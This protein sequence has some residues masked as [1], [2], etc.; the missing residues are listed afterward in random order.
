MQ[1]QEIIKWIK[2]SRETG[3]TDK[4]IREQLRASGWTK[5]HIDNVMPIANGP[6]SAK[7]IGNI[8]KRIQNDQSSK[9]IW[10]IVIFIIAVVGIGGLYFLGNYYSFPWKDNDNTNNTNSQNVFIN[11]S[12]SIVDQLAA[13]STLSKFTSYDELNNFLDEK[14]SQ[15]S[16]SYGR[17]N[18]LR[19]GFDMVMEGALP[20]PMGSSEASSKVVTDYST[21]NIQVAGVDEADIVKSDGEYVYTVSGKNVYIIKAY[22][23][24]ESEIVSTIALQSRPQNIYINGNN[25]IVYGQDDNLYDQSFYDVIR[26]SSSYTFFK[27]F[28]IANR[29]NPKQVRDLD[30]EGSYSNSRMIGDYVYFLTSQP[31]YGILEDYP[32]PMIIDDG[33][34]LPIEDSGVK[35]NCPDI[36]YV[37]APYQSY[38]FTN[39]AA[40]N[41]KNNAEPISNEVYLLSSSENMYVSQENIYLVYTKY[42]SEYQL[43]LESTKEL[44]YSRLSAKDRQRIDE[45]ESSPNYILSAD[46]KISKMYIIF[47]RY[48]SS[49]TAEGEEALEQELEE[50][51]KKKF[52]D[53]SKELEKTVIHKISIDKNKLQYE[54]S[55]EVTGHVLNQFS[56]D[57]QDGY[58]RI[59]TTKN[60]TWSSFGIDSDLESYS[61]VYI[62]DK[63]L[64][65]TGKVENLA[66]GEEIYSARFM[67]GR[68]YLVTFRQID[69][70]FAIDLTDP[71]Q[72][73]VLGQLKIPGFSSYLHPY[74]E[75][76][77][78]GFGKQAT[79]EGVVQGLKVSLFDVS[80]VDNLREIDTYE[81]GD[82]GSHSV[83]LDDHKAF[84]FSKD[85]NLLVIPVTLQ[86][87][88]PLE[89]YSYSYDHGA[90]VFNIT[91]DG[92]DFRKR[93]DHSDKSDDDSSQNY[94]Y[95]YN[96][97]NTS[98]RRSLYIEDTL[99][100]FSDKYLKVHTLENLDEVKS[101]QLV[102]SNSGLDYTIL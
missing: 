13:Q 72:P 54:G 88:D 16:Y 40:I 77:L 68:V 99:Y 36:Y 89:P 59:A 7:A 49:L 18:N 75:N 96:Y 95:G 41:V 25:L 35:C 26:P 93:L 31:T 5:G 22:P 20:N 39:V 63:N 73:K 38:N 57:E 42:I 30:F 65:V 60:R 76:T 43:S 82:S 69:P 56:M 79:D 15:A 3:F 94:R 91:K 29:K 17:A 34:L 90:M 8:E 10:V 50:K 53:I 48:T 92:F 4:Q 44:I 24:G 87:E 86:T 19:T 58:F 64:K 85:K 23:A 11:S 74:D 84:L 32:I 80:D 98:V 9:K 6:S 1:D 14:T 78:I 81:M 62:L 33:N 70:L 27:V 47:Q 71:T 28:D 46:E 55:G 97:Y 61:N 37:D 2:E 102:P 21:T 100:T 67:Q 45:I 12:T 66:K 52:A 51:M 101:L 83:A